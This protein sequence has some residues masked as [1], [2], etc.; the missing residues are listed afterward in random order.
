MI[1][2]HL[3]LRC[4]KGY[5]DK[6]LTPGLKTAAVS[7]AFANLPNSEQ[8]D[9]NSAIINYAKMPDTMEVPGCTSNRGILRVVNYDDV[10]FAIRTFRVSDRCTG[11]GSVS[12]SHTYVFTDQDRYNMLDC[13]YAMINREKYYD[14]YASVERRCDGLSSG[15]PIEINY[16]LSIHND[17]EYS[18]DSKL[19]NSLNIDKKTFVSIINAICYRV[20]YRGTVAL[21][22]PDITK[23][24]WEAEG[25]SILG[26]R[27]LAAVI[28]ILPKCVSR[29]FSGISY[30]NESP[31]YDGI[32]DITFRVMSGRIQEGLKSSEVSLIDLQ[33]NNISIGDVESNGVFA[34]YLWSIINNKEELRRF[35]GYIEE[36]F[37]E[38]V[39]DIPKMPTIM[40]M[41][42]EMF[43]Y[44][45]TIAEP[46]SRTKD[47]SALM[48]QI[49]KNFG[50]KILYFPKI[51]EIARSLMSN[52]IANKSG[53]SLLEKYIIQ[54]LKHKNSKNVSFRDEMISYIMMCL[55]NDSVT[56]ETV[57]YVVECLLQE[58]SIDN[59]IIKSYY[60]ET[61]DRIENDPNNFPNRSFISV[62][63]A[64][65]SS[66]NA[67][68]LLINKMS[69]I[70]TKA[71]Q[72]CVRS[73]SYNDAAAIAISM[74]S[75]HTSPSKLREVYKWCSSSVERL[76]G[77][78]QSKTIVAID[79]YLDSLQIVN[80][81]YEVV[82]FYKNFFGIE[83]SAIFNKCNALFPLYIKL[84]PS[85]GRET[86]YVTKWVSQYK[87][88]LNS[89]L[90]VYYSE[91]EKYLQSYKGSEAYAGYFLIEHSKISAL[92]DY[93]PKWKITQNIINL[94]P[95]DKKIN[96]S[97]Y[98]TQLCSQ[99]AMVGKPLDDY[100]EEMID[101]GEGYEYYLALLEKD[102]ENKFIMSCKDKILKKNAC[103]ELLINAAIKSQRITTLQKIYYN[104]WFEKNGRICFNDG[105]SP[106]KATI[107]E[108]KRLLKVSRGFC[109]VVMHN[110]CY[111]FI[112]VLNSGER[113]GYYSC[114]ELKELKRLIITYNWREYYRKYSLSWPAEPEPCE[115]I[116]LVIN[117][118]SY[119]IDVNTIMNNSAYFLNRGAY[120]RKPAIAFASR[121]IRSVLTKDKLDDYDERILKIKAFLAI[122]YYYSDTRQTK[123]KKLQ[124]FF[125]ALNRHVEDWCA[126]K[127]LFAGLA[128]ILKWKNNE[129]NTSSL[130]EFEDSFVN[131]LCELLSQSNNIEHIFTINNVIIPEI[132]T[133]ASDNVVSRFYDAAKRTGNDEYAKLF[134]RRREYRYNDG[135]SSGSMRNIIIIA[136]CVLLMLIIITMAYC[137]N[138]LIGFVTSIII[139]SINVI[140]SV[141]VFIGI[142]ID[143]KHR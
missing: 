86:N 21:L 74:L 125:E 133:L 119:N 93:I 56:K 27:V 62:M 137:I 115:F 118:E 4:T 61:L 141:I 9:L 39:D 98:I 51:E 45:K 95:T 47:Y 128:V 59:K 35:H 55:E 64:I 63:I 67:D 37:G 24:T 66:E 136:L 1:G 110:F 8:V 3:L 34:E 79:K 113:L 15:N 52:I 97:N 31:S 2:Q 75:N 80:N 65:Y 131:K 109:N 20:S 7:D 70:L 82:E 120:S 11:S 142:K 138:Q 58:G 132:M 127:Y 123:K 124:G 101:S 117:I 130:Q 122:I 89:K 88:L 100:F 17:F 6:S 135:S 54:V 23:D 41:V 57:D 16:D 106:V 26:E 5:Y 43:L 114:D 102:P 68:I 78:Y 134:K 53:S 10:L 108:E 81:N 91:S 92:A 83:E 107:E 22:L 28:R 30:W 76:A 90:G 50:I 69:S 13:P 129:R 33:K 72:S 38:Y 18:D 19:F 99:A 103:F 126:V 121:N 111:L 140:L 44:E 49:F 139:L 116:D 46:L 85:I 96:S 12:F 48:V 25:G 77:D 105:S 94:L 87:Y 143:K 40:D 32:K 42:T 71:Y 36:L 73:E 14:E 29:F 84:S 104:L 60:E 112:N